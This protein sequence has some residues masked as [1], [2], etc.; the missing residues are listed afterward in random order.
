MSN[1]R[2]SPVKNMEIKVPEF[3]L[4]VMVGVS[5]SGKSTFARKHFRPTEVLS[6]DAF[7]A[8]VADDDGDQS[9][10]PDAF[11][12][13]F[14]VAGIRLR[15]RRLTVIDATN[16]Q[17][18]AR[19]GLLELARRYH[20]LPV[21]IVL[22]MPNKI[23]MDRNRER[24]DR[25]FGKHVI[26]QQASQL[27]R[28]LRGLRREGFRHVYVLSDPKVVDRVEV[29]RVPLWTD[30]R[31]E[32]GPFDIIGDVHGCFDELRALLE[33][34]GY[35]VDVRRSEGVDDGGLSNEFD[36]THPEGRKAVFL[37]DL[38]DRGPNV[39]DVL[40]LV[41]NMVQHGNALCVP[42]NHEVKL[43]RK[44]NGK[45]VRVAHGLA[46]TLEQLEG[47][48]ATW[49]SE[50][51]HFLD[52][53]VSHY[54]LDHGRLIVAHAGLRE[55]LQGRASATVRSFALYGDTTG[56]IDEFGLPVRHDWAKEYRG[57]AM[58]VYGHTPTP[59]AEWLNR[60]ICID[61]GCVFGGKLTALRYPEQELVSVPA[62]EVWCEPV[63][64]LESETSEPSN[65]TAQ[66]QHDD[67]LWLD[68]VA[69]KRIV[70][71]RLRPNITIR[72]ENSTAA[73]EVMSRFAIDPRWLIY[74]PPTMSPCETSTVDEYLEYPTEAFAH[75]RAAGIESVVCQEKHMGSRAVV[76]VCRSEE[77]PARRFGI[78]GNG[79]GVCFT[80][81]GR[82]FFHDDELERAL[83]VH[84]RDAIEAAGLWD[85]L[86]T[87]WICLDCELMPWS[88]K[89]QA[90]ILEQ[91]A[92]TGAAGRA[93]LREA[94]ST[95]E[96]AADR[97]AD[98]AAQL[99]RHRTRLAM[100]DRYVEAFDHYC[101]PVASLSDYRLA[102]F[103]VLA[104][105]GHVHVD[106]DHVWHMQKIARVCDRGGALLHA[107]PY[108][109]VELSDPAS[110][111]DA[112]A[113]WRQRTDE[114]GEGMVVKPI[115]FVARGNRGLA[116]PAIKCRGPEY[117][118][119]IYGPEYRAP[120]HL[121][122]LR[123]RALSSKR[124][125]AIRE[126]A[127]GVEALER[128]VRKDPLRRVHECVFG[129][130]ALESEP[131]DPRL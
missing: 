80:R 46:Q 56:E 1:G 52:G 24:P 27:R 92:P 62:R 78:E 84:L 51:R 88:A 6:S 65:R 124:S 17:K 109:V 55:D 5:G 21:A 13:L 23:C 97:G 116:Q 53:L 31:S 26:P 45:N 50:L 114:G 85:E 49:M 83:L 11:D 77:V 74:L 129:V 119:I 22:D 103:H 100:L 41:M 25:A 2:I 61:T 90:L 127:L 93:A 57:K 39:P 89:A 106:R 7:R 113:W 105:E 28:S 96:R 34:L 112:T 108:R 111:A 95:L 107:T 38:V 94:V 73:L 43:L 110:E 120:E 131:I 19:R 126:F 16:T 14:H 3:S 33:E 64:P 54:V 40:R 8:L 118:R 63:R 75:Y 99:E 4:V 81:T 58:V 12:A 48:S 18:E 82:A 102:P 123:Q 67:L 30:K 91:Y 59:E 121:A 128:F 37:G 10:T 130:L 71:T 20:A 66:Q 36:V 42:G 68:D 60:T 117:L 15:N 98:V 104:S 122:R 69:G 35:R 115:D 32:T 70:S 101:W 72:A 79:V 87:D 44:L 29:E 125:L 47:Q 9:A 76:I 86:T